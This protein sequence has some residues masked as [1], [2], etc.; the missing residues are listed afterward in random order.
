[1]QK[2]HLLGQQRNKRRYGSSSIKAHKSMRSQS[3]GNGN[4]ELPI[5][6]LFIFRENFCF[7]NKFRNCFKMTYDAGLLLLLVAAVQ[8]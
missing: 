8:Q 6:S 2:C 7:A 3:A 4:W 1:M 5:H